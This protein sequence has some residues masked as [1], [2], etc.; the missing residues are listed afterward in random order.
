MFRRT[1]RAAPTLPFVLVAVSRPRRLAGFSY[2]GRHR[3]FLTFCV[4]DRQR[5]FVGDELVLAF[6]ALFRRTATQLGFAILAYCV[7]PDHVHLLVEGTSDTSDLRR[8]VKRVKQGTG[9]LYVRRNGGSLWQ[10]GYY[11]RVLRTEDDARELAPR[12]WGSRSLADAGSAGSDAA[13]NPA[14]VRG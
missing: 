2:I 14:Y 6:V 10:E 8:F 7:M 9:Q 4:V 1:R 12:F 5:L 13:R 11:E 3:Y